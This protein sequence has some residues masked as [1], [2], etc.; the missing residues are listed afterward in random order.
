MRK[1]TQFNAY[2]G[3]TARNSKDHIE[4]NVY[5]HMCTTLRMNASIT[6]IRHILF[7]HLMDKFTR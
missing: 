1:R 4:Y 5:T 6:R 2:K 3:I 7:Q